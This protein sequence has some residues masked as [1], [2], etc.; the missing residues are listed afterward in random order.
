MPDSTTDN[1][2]TNLMGETSASDDLGPGTNPCIRTSLLD[3]SPSPRNKVLADSYLLAEIFSAFGNHSYNQGQLLGLALVS[4]TFKGPAL[5]ILWSK[6]KSYLPLIKLLPLQEIESQLYSTGEFSPSNFHAYATRIREL[7]IAQPSNV[8]CQVLMRLTKELAGAPFLPNLR[9]VSV[10]HLD[11][12]AASLFTLL[13]SPTLSE[14]EFEGSSLSR[15]HLPIVVVP[16]IS[17]KSYIKKLSLKSASYDGLDDE[18]FDSIQTFT[19]LE[20]LTIALPHRSVNSSLLS[21]I[22]DQLR[23][24]RELE[25]DVRIC[26][27]VNKHKPTLSVS[28]SPAYSNLKSVRLKVDVV[29]PALRNGRSSV[30]PGYPDSLLD[31]MTHLTIIFH[32]NFST[33]GARRIRERASQAPSLKTVVL[34]PWSVKRGSEIRIPPYV[35]KGLFAVPTLEDIRIEAWI[36]DDDETTEDSFLE[37][38]IKHR[39]SR[40]RVNSPQFIDPLRTIHLPKADFFCPPQTLRTVDYVARNLGGLES[41]QLRLNSSTEALDDGGARLFSQTEH[42]Q[43]AL[44]ELVVVEARNTR[45]PPMDHLTIAQF[46]DRTFPNLASIQAYTDRVD[47]PFREEQAQSWKLINRL[48]SDARLLRIHMNHSL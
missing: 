23:N 25:M 9:R 10:L 14:V 43:C 44:R 35:L 28:A 21:H 20:A 2:Q 42:T 39:I 29:G 16:L 4:T 12:F 46:L 11:E 13:L 40:I 18:F 37:K 45:F 3:E 48:R 41:L 36:A 24:L 8:S 47:N 38:M 32:C 33:S 26:D 1:P 27:L 31:H 17:H 5:D 15:P 19:N 7:E 34:Q 6:M 22:L 30:L